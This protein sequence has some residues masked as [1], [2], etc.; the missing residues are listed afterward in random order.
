MPIRCCKN[1]VPPERHSGCHS[2]CVKYIK[3]KEEWEKGK[4]RERKEKK[5]RSA[6]HEIHDDMFRK[7][8]RKR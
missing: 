8:R 3:E 5:C 7:R 4:E 1:C 6:I 2:K